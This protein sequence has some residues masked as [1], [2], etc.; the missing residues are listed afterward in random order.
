[1]MAL[2]ILVAICVCLIMVGF[3]SSLVKV[4]VAAYRSMTQWF[5]RH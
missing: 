5:M 1:M 2:W 4:G 3:V